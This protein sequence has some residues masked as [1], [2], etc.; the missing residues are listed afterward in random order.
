MIKN[1]LVALQDAED[2]DRTSLIDMEEDNG[3]R[4]DILL[5]RDLSTWR[6]SVDQVEQRRDEERGEK[7]YTFIIS[8][9]RVNIQQGIL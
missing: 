7:Y 5:S 9:R 8:I 3:G 6:V 1:E 4:Q 2:N